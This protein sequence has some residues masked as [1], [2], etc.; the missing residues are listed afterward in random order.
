MQYLNKYRSTVVYC[1]VFTIL[2]TINHLNAQ[3]VEIPTI[4]KLDLS[5]LPSHTFSKFWYQ[6]GTDP[7]GKA[8][9]IPLMVLKGDNSKLV[10]GLTAA[11]HGNEL[12]GIPVIQKVIASIDPKNLK[13][14]IIGIPG[15]N[16]ES[17]IM[18][19]RRFT[20]GEDLNRI[21]PGKSNGSESEQRAYIILNELISMMDINIDMHTASFGRE[22]CFYSR[23][24]M[25]DD[26]LAALARLQY[27][28]IIVDNAGQPSFGS[29]AGMTSRAASI[30]KGVKSITVEYGNPQV[31]QTEMIQRGAKGV[32]NALKWLK[33]VPGDIETGL[34]SVIC[35]SSSWI[36]TDTG[37]YL[38]VDVKLNQ[39]IKK[40]QKIATLRNPF[41][42]VTKEYFSP[43][44]GVVIGR[45]SNPVA[46]Q[47]ARIIH[48]GKF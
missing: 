26:T 12:N 17:I 9:S 27:A 6:V 44:D 11:I 5:K 21:F 20:D 15:I 30:E 3:S 39:K 40:G 8:V 22:N 37:G 16:P 32:T 43:T 38:E 33:M 29:A 46:T 19:D 7:F 13:G 23:A 41:G 2:L 35:T 42:D 36:Y 1:V 48:L 28:D 24:D 45:S 14:T 31:Y 34:T 25:K 18:N 4:K 10:V 47:G